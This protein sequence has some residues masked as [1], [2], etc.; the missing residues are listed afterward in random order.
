M[1][2]LLG[3]IAVTLVIAS[4]APAPVF[5]QGS[6]GT[7]VGYVRDATGA[8][9][10]GV[11]VTATSPVLIGS[12]TAVT[13]AQGYYRLLNLPPG[14]YTLVAEISGFSTHRQE[15][16]TMR[17]GATF[18]SN[19]QMKLSTVEESVTVVGDSPMLEVGTPTHAVN[20]SGEFQR[21]VPIQSRK[22]YTD[23]LE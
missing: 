6:E 12:R 8:V 13:D 1:R 5:A 10:P 21:E 20:I 7:L 3:A 19:I 2:T 15:G 11:T 4:G 9:L 14:D 17:A 16:V 23:F 18:T 22:S